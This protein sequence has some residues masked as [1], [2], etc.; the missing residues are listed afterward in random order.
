M[1]L[2]DRLGRL[3]RADF[4]RGGEAGLLADL[5]RLLALGAKHLA[6][7]EAYV[8]VA[9]EAR[10]T[11]AT[12]ALEAQHD[13][14]RARFEMLD[15]AIRAVE[16]A[17]PADRPG[18]GRALYLAFSGFVAEDLEH[19][20]QEEAEAWPQLCALFSDEELMAIE[21]AIVGSL[22]PDDMMDFMRLMLPATNPAE[23]Q[24]LLD[25]VEANAPPEAYVAIAGL[26]VRTPDGWRAAPAAGPPA[27]A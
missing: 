9:L 13:H 2:G 25:G 21:M 24:A 5:R 22:P 19:M 6:H 8:H 26:G 16:A 17:A 4:A 12:V 10:R 18:L 14:H 15:A 27:A 20:R 23:R 7:E 1:A 3:G 11:G